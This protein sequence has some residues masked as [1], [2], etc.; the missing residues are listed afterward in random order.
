MQARKPE[1]LT[2]ER[3]TEL[4]NDDSARQSDKVLLGK[5]MSII[6]DVSAGVQRVVQSGLLLQM[7][8]YR[9]G[10]I[11]RGWVRAKINLVEYTI[12][13]GTMAFLTPGSIAEPLECSADFMLEGMAVSAELVHLA[14]NNHLPRIFNGHKT[15]GRVRVSEETC[16]IGD[17]MLHL[18]FDVSHKTRYDNQVVLN[19]IAAYLNFFDQQFAEGMEM[20]VGHNVSERFLFER[21]LSLVNNHSRKEHHLGF[22]AGKMCITVRYLSTMIRKASGVTAKEWIDRSL[23]TQAKVMLSYSNKNVM[24]IADELNFPNASF[25]CKYFKRLAGCTP[26]QYRAAR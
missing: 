18:L 14:L 3:M 12:G 21:F 1:K 11:R 25:F 15:D 6:F 19:L 17:R 23:V 7:P 8:D 10:F 4:F 20:P 22:Y 13:A 24:E 26:Q 9:C 5:E 16:G 2:F